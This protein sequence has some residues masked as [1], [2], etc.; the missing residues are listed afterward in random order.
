M[1]RSARCTVR[2]YVFSLLTVCGGE[3]D[4]DSWVLTRGEKKVPPGVMQHRVGEGDICG[5]MFWATQREGHFTHASR[6]PWASLIIPFRHL[7]K[8]WLR[9]REI[10]RKVALL[11]WHRSDSKDYFFPLHH[12]ACHKR[13]VDV[14]I[15]EAL[16]PHLGPK[17]RAA[18]AFPT[19]PF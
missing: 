7:R 9:G 18:S 17:D 6:Q 12:L 14:N 4:P 16:Q 10:D 13:V 2:G 1:E 19:V 3:N 11:R 15:G 5:Y 8:L